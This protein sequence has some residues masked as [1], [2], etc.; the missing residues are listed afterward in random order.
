MLYRIRNYLQS[1]TRPVI[2]PL[3]VLTS[4]SYTSQDEKEYNSTI[5]RWRSMQSHRWRTRGKNRDRARYQDRKDWPCFH[6]CE[7]A[8]WSEIQDPRQERCHPCGRRL[9]GE[10]NL[11]HLA[12]PCALDRA[13]VAAPRAGR[14]HFHSGRLLPSEE[15]RWYHRPLKKEKTTKCI[16]RLSHPR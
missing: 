4:D 12:V 3:R 10:L 5:K 11:R 13:R 14:Y 1:R 16:G 2:G 6:Y 15:S 7:T 8:K 9:A